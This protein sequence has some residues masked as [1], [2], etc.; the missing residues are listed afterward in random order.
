MCELFALSSRLPTRVT[1]SLEEFARHGGQTNH[2]SDGWGLAFYEDS[3]A[4]VF[5]EVEPAAYSEWMNFLL[6]H[7]YQSRCVISHIRRA[8]QGKR[9]LRNTQPF[10]REFQGKRHVFCH[11][12]DL[13]GIAKLVSLEHFSPIGETD[14]EYAF[15]YLLSELGKLVITDSVGLEQQIAAVKKVFDRLSTIGIANFIYSDGRYLYAYA[16]KRFQTDGCIRPP[17][18]YYLCRSCERDQEA[19]PLAGVNIEIDE[20]LTSQNIVLFA[21]VPLSN[22]NWIPIKPNQLIVAKDGRIIRQHDT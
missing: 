20:R 6:N 17:G 11:N 21:S 9:A 4:Q 15:C 3:Y 7:Q 1:F 2:H 10:S 14:S 16:N 19:L 18:M 22:E 12:G 5:R 8:T 13:L